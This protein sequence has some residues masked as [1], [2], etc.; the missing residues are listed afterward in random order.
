M[1]YDPRED[2]I[3]VVR[4][5]Q[6]AN[7]LSSETRRGT[8]KPV[9][10]LDVPVKMMSSTDRDKHHLYI[11]VEMSWLRYATL[12]TALRFAG[13]I[14]TGFWVWSLRRG[15]SFVRPVGVIKTP[16]E[17]ARARNITHGWIRRRKEGSG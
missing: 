6:Q 15:A 17:Y 11:D 1:K 2:R 3:P 4:S 9:I 7:L 16:E 13:V 14:E 12:L 5:D 10:D 8:H